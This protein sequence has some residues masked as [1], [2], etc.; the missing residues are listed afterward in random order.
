ML[1]LSSVFF[2]LLFTS[3]VKNSTKN[4]DDR[5]FNI[6]EN[7]R[8][9]KVK[10]EDIKLEFDYL[11][12]A[13]KLLEYQ[14]LYFENELSKKNITEIKTL[15]FVNKDFLIDDLEIINKNEK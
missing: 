5:I 12:S 9:L 15:N 14:N 11:G 3:L 1:I 6:K 8:D 7:I 10:F 2:L 4:I 13:E